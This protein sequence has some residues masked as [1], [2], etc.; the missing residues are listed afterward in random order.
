MQDFQEVH[1]HGN[2]DGGGLL[3]SEERIKPLQVDVLTDAHTCIQ[4]HT[5]TWDLAPRH[6]LVKHTLSTK[7][8]GK[9][10]KRVPSIL[11]T[12]LQ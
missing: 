12:Y 7:K 2:A 10:E 1:T 8:L 3:F 5:P 4:P 9:N 6:R 11:K